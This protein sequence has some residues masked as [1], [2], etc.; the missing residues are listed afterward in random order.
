V[1]P[2][3]GDPQGQS[4][5][6]W[7]FQGSEYIGRRVRRPVFLKTNLP[8]KHLHEQNQED[9]APDAQAVGARAPT[10]CGDGEVVAWRQQQRISLPPLLRA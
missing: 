1:V 9:A 10:A 6:G 8:K 5:G 3:C 2:L 7:L 4:V